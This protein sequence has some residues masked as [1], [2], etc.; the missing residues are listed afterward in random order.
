[1]KEIFNPRRIAVVGA[2]A[3]GSL[4]GGLLC[5]AGLE[6]T[7]IDIWQEHINRVRKEGLKILGYGGDRMIKKIKATT[8][9]KEAGKMDVVI[10]QT[11]RRDTSQALKNAL[12]L[13]ADNTVTVSFQNGLGKEEM[14]GEIVGMERV[15]GGTTAQGAS[16]VESGVI[17]NA[18]N[19]PTVIGELDG[20]ITERVRKIGEAFN[21]E[22]FQ[23]IVTDNIQLAIWKKI[24][25]NVAINPISA[26]C[27]FT[28]GEIFNIPEVKE[29]IFEA[30]DEAARVANAAGIELEASET[31]DVLT[32]IMGKEGTGTNRSGM[33]VDVLQKRKTEIDFIN[34]AIVELGKKYGIPTPI[35]KTLV[36]AIKGLERNFN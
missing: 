17:R 2:G 36:A 5:E 34:G 9:P 32:Q 3:M 13:F 18:G 10:V 19:L 21:T 23:V 27:N 22:G 8:D 35:N 25:A 7:L 14:I 29:V 12:H 26:L 20:S 31:K 6:V 16:F 1:M 33:L 30:L 4:I 11:K 28:V 24:M 15:I